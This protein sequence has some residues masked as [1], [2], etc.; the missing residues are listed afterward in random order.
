MLIPKL[1]I[2]NVEAKAV[3][4]K[5]YDNLLRDLETEKQKRIEME[6]SLEERISIMEKL[7]VNQ[8]FQKDMSRD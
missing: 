7:Q 1:S 6:K 5:E 8:E 2:E 4:T 3:T